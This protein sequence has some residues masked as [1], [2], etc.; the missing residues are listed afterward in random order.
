MVRG[1]TAVIIIPTYNEVEV[2]GEMIDHLFTK[3]FP[4]VTDWR[5]HLL[6]VDDTSPDGTYKI[7]QDKQKKYPNLHLYLNEEKRGIGWAY[8]VGF[9]YAMEKLAADVLIEFDADFQHP[10]KDIPILL[11][12][13]NEGYD[14]VLG[15][16]KVEGG[17]NPKGWGFKRVFFS[18]VG[19]SIARFVLFFPGKNF[20]RIT[21]PTT[22]LKAS[23]VKGFVDKINLD[24]L[25]SYKFGYKLELLY[26]MVA[27]LKAKV[28]E[29]PLQFGL[30]TRGESKISSG[31]A[32]DIFRTVVLL[33]WHDPAT[34]SFLKFGVVGFVGYLVN[35]ISLALFARLGWSEWLIWLLSTELAIISNFTWNNLWTFAEK[36]FTHPL[37]L[38]RKFLQF[39]LTSAG[40]LVIQTVMGNLLVNLFGSQYRQ[41]YLPLIIVFLVLP[42]NWLMYNKIIWK[43]GKKRA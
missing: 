29:I 14:Y 30:R 32:K 35:A 15:S 7:V 37:D 28:T 24:K 9:R 43:A 1:K 10:P 33:R 39:N 18:E 36:K 2:I 31:T 40:A 13:I 8:A 4:E 16:R 34:Q 42:Y 22:G 41:L 19:G 12:K 25:Y 5:M 26:R 20:F 38:L 17:S 23:R 27:N 21:D 11:A 6:V 3:T